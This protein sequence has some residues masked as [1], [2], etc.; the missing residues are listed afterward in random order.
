MAKKIRGRNEG[1]IYQRSNGKACPNLGKWK[2]P[3][4]IFQDKNRCQSLAQE[5]ATRYPARIRY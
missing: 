5:Y 2:P 3:W 4:E 1:S